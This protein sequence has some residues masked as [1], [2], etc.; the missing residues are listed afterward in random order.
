MNKKKLSFVLL[1][2][3]F[4]PMYI[5]VTCSYNFIKVFVYF[6]LITSIFNGFYVQNLLRLSCCVLFKNFDFIL[7]LDSHK[8]QLIELEVTNQ[9]LDQKP[10]IWSPY[11]SCIYLNL[12]DIGT[13]T[14]TCIYL[15]FVIISCNKNNIKN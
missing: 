6:Y 15:D 13:N 2:F 5:I 11:K 8:N 14:H 3:P 9:N 10:R 4:W 12:Y 7:V 1:F